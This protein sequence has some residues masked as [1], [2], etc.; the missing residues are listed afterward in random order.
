MEFAG[1]LVGHIK[2]VSAYIENWWKYHKGINDYMKTLDEKLEELNCRKQDREARKMEE[3]L[4]E[5]RRPRKRLKKEVELWLGKVEK[6][7]GEVKDLEKRVE[8]VSYLAR[9][10]LGKIVFAKISEVEELYQK[11]NF[12]DGLIEVVPAQLGDIL[13][14][15]KVLGGEITSRRKV[16]EIWECLVHDEVRKIGV[17][18]MSGIGKTTILK[19]INNRLLEHREKF[20]HVIWVTVSKASSNVMMLQD[21]IACKLNLDISRYDDETTRAAKLYEALSEKKRYVLILDDLWEMYCLEEVGV[22]EPTRDNGCKLVLS[23]QF[24]HISHGMSCKSIQMELLSKEEAW[25]LFL[26]IVGHDVLS[27]PHLYAIVQDIVKECGRLPLAIVTIGGSLKGVVDYYEWKTVL[28]ELRAPRKGP[29]D[30]GSIVLQKLQVSYNR[31][32][33]K[34]LQ[35]CLLY[36]ALYPEDYLIGRVKL[37]ECL[38]VEGIIEGMNSRLIEFAKGH[39]M[40]NKLESASLLEGSSNKYGH[41]FVKMHDLVRDMAMNIMST[42]YLVKA[43]V[44]LRDMPGEEKWAEDLVRVSLMRNEL[45]N[46]PSSAAPKCYRLS[47]LVLNHNK[48]LEEIPDCFFTHMNKLEVLDLSF[49]NIKILPRSVSNLVNLKALL[50]RGCNLLVDMPSLA[51]LRALRSLDCRDIGIKEVPQGLEMLV[52]LR[53]LDLHC[54]LLKTIPDGILPRLSHLQDLALP[55]YYSRTLKVNVEELASLRKLENFEASF[56]DIEHFNAFVSS[57]KDREMITDYILYVGFHFFEKFY[58]CKNGIILT[59][60][61]IRQNVTRDHYP[62]IV[63]K[64][65]QILHIINCLFVSLCKLVA[66]LTGMIDL[67]TLILSDCSETEYV[68]YSSS[69]TVPVFPRLEELKL[70]RL[71]SLRGLVMNERFASRLLWPVGIFSSLKRLLV[72]DCLSMKSLFTPWLLPQLQNLEDIKVHKCEKMIEIIASMPDEDDEGQTQEEERNDIRIALP[73]LRFLRLWGLPKLRSISS[74]RG[75]TNL[76]V[77]SLEEILILRCP[78]LKRIDALF[79]EKR[80]SNHPSLQ[81]IKVDK[82]WWD[83]LEWDHLDDKN[84]LDRLCKFHDTVEERPHQHR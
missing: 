15:R 67:R 32:K 71:W 13:P 79:G 66:P 36:C 2:T 62:L 26:D 7:N 70:D 34:K 1:S 35:D 18:G 65:I 39:A 83:S 5:E 38:I 11:G 22:P 12:V 20:G 9:A 73:K 29:Q 69:F 54:K 52:N 19:H 78:K 25:K 4:P 24:L 53:Y 10:S 49:T 81:K 60:C 27:I 14:T 37:I 16:E 43:G 6:I 59:N 46:I 41:R 30:M 48:R 77:D 76:V 68:L 33:D 44:G 61:N 57:F 31:L 28:E 82:N 72:F 45:S 74:N 64:G 17:Y 80:A 84:T 50:L 51:N 55:L 21:A 58:Y 3:L 8:E 75:N 40:L 47:T 23:T 56:L 42:H 63:L